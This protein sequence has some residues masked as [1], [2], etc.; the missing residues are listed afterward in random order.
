M[1]GQM[2]L[3]GCQNKHTQFLLLFLFNL[4]LFRLAVMSDCWMSIVSVMWLGWER[5]LRS[6][7]SHVNNSP[8]WSHS[9]WTSG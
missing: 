2:C 7:R 4:T 6:R 5:W 1:E 9:L 3:N 8:R